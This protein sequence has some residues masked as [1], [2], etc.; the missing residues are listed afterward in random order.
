MPTGQDVLFERFS[1][2]AGAFIK[3]DSTNSQ[4]YK[5]L[6]RAAKAKLRLRIRATYLDKDGKKLQ[7][8]ALGPIPVSA[9]QPVTALSSHAPSAG[10]AAPVASAHP[11]VEP[12]IQLPSRQ[13]PAQVDPQKLSLL[14]MDVPMG[15]STA[16]SAPKM[17]EMQRKPCVSKLP[18][19]SARVH[20]GLENLVDGFGSQYV[21]SEAP[22]PAEFCENV[23]CEG[24]CNQYPVL[25]HPIPGISAAPGQSFSICCNKCDASIH[26]PHWHC[27]I[28]DNGD[29]DLCQSCFAQGVRCDNV[30]A[31]I[32]H[33]L[34]Q[35]SVRNGK[36]VMSDTERYTPKRTADAE[37]NA[38][39]PGPFTAEIKT[40][41]SNA[42]TAPTRTCNSCISVF[43]E[44]N[45]VTCTTCED[46]DLCLS[47]HMNMKH[48]HHPGH[49]F[50]P[51]S[52]DATMDEH[53]LNL[54]TPGR[55]ARHRAVCDGCD[56]VCL[57]NP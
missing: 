28:C 19:P 4:V 6:L 47:C 20:P 15:R 40:D 45:F 16:S 36:V 51:A 49:S 22:L 52:D 8:S 13:K 21:Y 29:F 1:D 46:Y 5:Q 39:V 11:A 55:Y 17:P 18:G 44:A 14:D 41:L 9:V 27:G 25:C 35:R 30:E 53:A 3:L 38:T 56:Q 57:L 12:R 23:S 48:G 54:C 2:S 42:S 43:N 24:P 50:I 34:I 32:E 37:L 26:G 10:T 7:F 33:W 31:A